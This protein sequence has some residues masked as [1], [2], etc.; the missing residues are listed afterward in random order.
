MSSLFFIITLVFATL[1]TVIGLAL[2]LVKTNPGEDAPDIVK[3]FYST[4]ILGVIE[5][6]LIYLYLLVIA[7]AYDKPLLGGFV[8]I[9]NLVVFFIMMVITADAAM[10]LE[11]HQDKHKKYYELAVGLAAFS[12]TVFGLL[13][14]GF[15]YPFIFKKKKQQ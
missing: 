2:D 14:I 11:K 13:L 8:M 10:K 6:M 1:A 4:Y 15:I 7:Y 5:V 12:G 3:K 9:L